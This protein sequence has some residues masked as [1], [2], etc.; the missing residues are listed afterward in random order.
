MAQLIGN[1][2]SIVVILGGTLRYFS[3]FPPFRSLW[4]LQ[5]VVSELGL[6]LAIPLLAVMI[7]NLFF[8]LES[9][10]I[11]SR[12][13]IIFST[14]AIFVALLPALETIGQERN[15]LWDLSYGRGNDQRPDPK[16]SSP[17][18][19]KIERPLFKFSDFFE[20][21]IHPVP[22]TEI[23]VTRDG[24]SLPILVYQS[25]VAKT[26]HRWI[27]SIHGGGWSSGDPSDFDHTI[28]YL[29]KAG[30]SV[31]SPAYRLAPKS[32]WPDQQ[33]DAEAAYEYVAKNSDRF[34]L[35]LNDLWLLG[36]SAG[37][38][39]ALKLAYDSKIVKNV[40]GVIALYT[41]TDID[42]GYHWTEAEDI[43]DSRSL[44]KEFIGATPDQDPE[45]YKAASP[46]Q[47]VNSHSP[48]TLLIS[49]RAD[50]L[51]WYRHS[52]RLAD[53]LKS[54]KVRVI[55]IE[56]PWATHGFDYFVNSPAGQITRNAIF[57]FMETD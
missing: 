19:G 8:L 9:N 13:S 43:L 44:L 38:Q 47:D 53:A 39:I 23:F 31:V 29:L 48:K 17:Y 21:P 26:P 7:F 2:F 12:L 25:L 56:L 1:L 24:S 40:K 49:G 50:P 20:R 34:E 46:I 42:F 16:I 27:L 11:I 6:L 33:K 18:V 55:H 41:P 5:L 45:K 28:P 37:G 36:R 10:Q 30:I 14:L 54:A 3:N 52:N 32:T 51:T 22:Q 15:W 35:D 57:R 4:Y